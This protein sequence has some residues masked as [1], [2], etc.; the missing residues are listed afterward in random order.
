MAA[1]FPSTLPTLAVMARRT[2]A[3]DDLLAQARAIGY[4]RGEYNTGV[5]ECFAY[6][7]SIMPHPHEVDECYIHI[8]FVE[9]DIR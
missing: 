8:K 2:V 7:E 4:N 6:T 5:D 9:H 3:A 1:D